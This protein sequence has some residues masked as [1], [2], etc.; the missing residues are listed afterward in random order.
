MSFFN[1]YYQRVRSN[2]FDARETDMS[3]TSN[4][5][6]SSELER[7]ESLDSQGL[8]NSQ[9]SV[10]VE[11]QL[12]LS[13]LKYTGGDHDSRYDI[14]NLISSN[15]N[16][17]C[18]EHNHCSVVVQVGG[19]PSDKGFGSSP[20]LPL[21]SE[22]NIVSPP[23]L[24][25]TSP[26]QNV[27]I[28]MAMDYTS[29]L[30][31][32]SD[33]FIN[34]SGVAHMF[35]TCD[36]SC[37]MGTSSFRNG[38]ENGFSNNTLHSA[39]NINDSPSHETHVPRV[40]NSNIEGADMDTTD[41]QNFIRRFVDQQERAGSQVEQ[42]HES[43]QRES[44]YSIPRASFFGSNR[45]HSIRETKKYPELYNLHNSIRLFENEL[46]PKRRVRKP[47]QGPTI[48]PIPEVNSELDF[49]LDEK[50]STICVEYSLGEPKYRLDPT[51]SAQELDLAKR[52]LR[53]SRW[54]FSKQNL[55]KS[56]KKS[57][58]GSQSSRNSIRNL[59]RTRNRQLSQLS[60]RSPDDGQVEVIPRPNFGD[61]SI[62]N[63]MMSYS[64]SEDSGLSTDSE[65]DEDLDDS[66]PDIQHQR[67]HSGISFDIEN[68]SIN[69]SLSN[70]KWNTSGPL[71]PV[72]MASIPNKGSGEKRHLNIKFSEGVMARYL[73]FKFSNTTTRG[74]ANVD[75]ESLTVHGVESTSPCIQ[76][77]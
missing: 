22:I 30:I 68:Y 8:S 46:D 29:D 62:N 4:F 5:L 2:R 19:G 74:N 63:E 50:E 9:V 26:V 16:A 76:M 1:P 7:S 66:I 40:L 39:T 67:Y 61:V 27:A 58:S 65:S 53:L 49:I 25:Y 60:Q 56:S 71:H 12:P 44:L 18:A 32:R 14:S 48:Q 72:A 37:K 41:L 15:N 11:S 52:R 6:S 13:V 34:S 24:S 42:P 45:H 69:T 77:I 21:I 36:K 20:S 57:N 59:W 17:Y 54:K 55:G 43:Y 73:V 70:T 64:E 35:N 75:I 38:L 33:E 31:E 3:F 51:T 47:R 10:H 28:F 23:S